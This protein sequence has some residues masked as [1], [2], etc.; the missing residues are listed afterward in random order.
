MSNH[1]NYFSIKEYQSYNKK[2]CAWPRYVERSVTQTSE[3]EKAG[4]LKKSS[5]IVIHPMSLSTFLGNIKSY[6]IT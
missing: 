3:L 1:F 5:Y 2:E 6:E 4:I